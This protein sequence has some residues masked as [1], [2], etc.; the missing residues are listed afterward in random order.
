MLVIEKVFHATILRPM[1]VLLDVLWSRQANLSIHELLVIERPAQRFAASEGAH[2][3]RARPVTAKE[4][5]RSLRE[6]K[7]PHSIYFPSIVR[8]ELKNFRKYF[9]F[10]WYSESIHP[11]ILGFVNQA[12]ATRKCN[13]NCC[14]SLSWNRTKQF[15]NPYCCHS[16]RFHATKIV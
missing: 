7:I 2:P 10:S 15:I 13:R 6:R 9:F 5:L 16:D 11:S 14:W 1:M 8:L 3:T 12:K 4:C